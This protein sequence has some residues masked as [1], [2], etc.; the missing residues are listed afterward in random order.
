MACLQGVQ[1]CIDQR[2]SSNMV[3]LES[4]L[5]QKLEV[6]LEQ[7]ELLWK[8]KSKIDWVNFG[9]RNTSFFHSKA[10]ARTH[11]KDVQTLKLSDTDWCS[12]HDQLRDA[13]TVF[14]ATLFDIEAGPHHCFRSVVFSLSFPLVLMTLLSICLLNQKSKRPFLK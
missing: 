8:Q 2:R 14:F 10:K 6:L 7:E 4:K 12:N 11:K 3:N 9:D 5:L 1:R 13:A